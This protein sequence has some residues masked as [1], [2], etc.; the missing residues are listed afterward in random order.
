[1]SD[2]PGTRLRGKRKDTEA[3][4][5]SGDSGKGRTKE[6]HLQKDPPLRRSG[7]VGSASRV[8]N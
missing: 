6:E 8:K 7:A 2:N 1:M 3:F 5:V 4:R